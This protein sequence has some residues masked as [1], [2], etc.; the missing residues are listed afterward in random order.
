MNAVAQN[1]LSA[2]LAKAQSTIGIAPKTGYNPHF[3]SSFSTLEDLISVSR[4]SLSREGISVVQYQDV[5]GEYDFLVTELR[6]ASGE[7]IIGRARIYLKDKTDIQKLGG[8]VSYLKRYGYASICGIATSENDDDGNSLATDNVI[9][10]KQ[11]GYLKVLLKDQPGREEKVCAHYAI[12]NLAKLP[13]K[14]MNELVER[15]KS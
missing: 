1:N 6:H 12:D 10:D 5:D 15:L 8:A 7:S 4:E 9:T 3:R 2:A 11:L 13:M 14:H